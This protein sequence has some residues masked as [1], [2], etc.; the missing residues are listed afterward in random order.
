MIQAFKDEDEFSCFRLYCEEVAPQLSFSNHS[1]WHRLLLQAGQNQPFIRHAIIAI[2]ALNRSMGQLEHS[3]SPTTGRRSKSISPIGSG[4]PNAT[5]I[6]A[7][8]LEH[9][10]KFLQGAKLKLNLPKEQGRRIAMIACLLVVCIENMQYQ[11]ESAM[12]HAQKGLLLLE[13]LKSSTPSSGIQDGLS[14]PT[15]GNVEDELVHQFNRMELQ[16][17]AMFD[18]RIPSEHR[19]LK[20]EGQLSIK[21]MPQRFNTIDQARLYLH[22]IMRRIFH[23]IGS[24]LADDQTDALIRFGDTQDST[25]HNSSSSVFTPPIDLSSWLRNAPEEL[26]VEQEIYAAE[27][28]RWAQAYEPLYRTTVL[29]PME[30]FGSMLLKLQSVAIGVRMAGHLSNTELVYDKYMPEFREIVNL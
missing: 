28:R 13:D 3:Q 19:K 26:S 6:H 1:V 25:F 21:D 10:G 17:M 11:Y 4:D 29:D 5:R 15:P 22:L 14:S 24:A 2:G 16:V 9:Y 18:A 23:F 30:S 27:N 20:H 8:A 12:S 7:F